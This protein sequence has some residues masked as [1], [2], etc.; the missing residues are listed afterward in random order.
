MWEIL[1]SLYVTGVVVFALL[2]LLFISCYGLL[3]AG[4]H[5]MGINKG[6]NSPWLAW[7]PLGQYYVIGAIIEEF[8][9]L[10]WKI[11]NAGS[12]LGGL[13]VV[14]FFFSAIIPFIG[15]ILPLALFVLGV[16][17]T[18]KLLSLKGSSSPLGVILCSL[19]FFPVLPI[20]IFN[21]RNN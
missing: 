11:S 15:W 1:D 18:Y 3:S 10:D 6:I 8:K 17:A 14:T 20:V 21:L 4:L 19:V 16:A 12:V 2:F 5:I 7:I 9:L 13:A